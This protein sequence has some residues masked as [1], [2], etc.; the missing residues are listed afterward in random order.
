[1]PPPPA[2]LPPRVD[3]NLCHDAAHELRF[4]ANASTA[5]RFTMRIAVSGTHRAG[6]ST[7]VEELANHL[8][9]HVMVDEPYHLMVEDGYEFSHPPSLED[10]EAQLE[11]SLLE[12]SERSA[13]RCSIA[14]RWIFW[15]T[16]RCTQTPRSS[17]S[18][19]G[20]PE[21]KRR[22]EHS[23]SPGNLRVGV[24]CH[25]GAH[26]APNPGAVPQKAGTVPGIFSDHRFAADV[27]VIN[28]CL[29]VPGVARAS[30]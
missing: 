5:L 1:V 12:L 4:H 3:T 8:P 23:A 10:F 30:R 29:V 22:F 2:F 25:I 9:K 14:A 7:L 15:L 27:T 19:S 20:Y 28:D 17:T 16:Q 18:T 6:K 24:R 13:T 11:R 21:C 26:R